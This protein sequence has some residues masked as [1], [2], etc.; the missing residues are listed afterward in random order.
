M[1]I[2][3]DIDG[4][5]ANSGQAMLDVVNKKHGLSLWPDDVKDYWY[6]NPEV[7]PYKDLIQNEWR[8]SNTNGIISDCSMMPFANLFHMLP[9]TV[10]LV[11]HRHWTNYDLTVEWLFNNDFTGSFN[12]L[13]FVDGLKSSH[14]PWDYFI[15]DCQDNVLDLSSSVTKQILLVNHPYNIN[16]DIPGNVTRVSGWIEIIEFFKQEVIKGVI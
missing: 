16:L 15:E 11:T 7:L 5:L 10:E 8:N 3:V 4:V 6:N 1:L 9:G 2:G 13:V 12:K 14:G